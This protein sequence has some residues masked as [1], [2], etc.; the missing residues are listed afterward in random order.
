MN[1][2]NT[3]F[4]KISKEIEDD[5]KQA[6]FIAIDEEFSGLGTEQWRS[7]C[8]FDTVY[9][10]LICIDRCKQE[11]LMRY[12]SKHLIFLFHSSSKI[13]LFQI[14]ITCFFP[15]DSSGTYKYQI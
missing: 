3:N 5:I 10:F 6:Y 1:V 12:I 8:I 13:M 7:G 4:E 11:Y 15:S 2:D 14:G 9:E